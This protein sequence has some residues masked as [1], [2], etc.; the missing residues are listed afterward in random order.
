MFLSLSI[1]LLSAAPAGAQATPMPMN[2]AAKPAKPI[3][4]RQTDTGSI[5]PVRTCHSPAEWKQIDDAHA[6]QVDEFRDQ[7]NAHSGGN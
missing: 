2:A 7:A 5:M 6:K 3:C 1:L 4:R